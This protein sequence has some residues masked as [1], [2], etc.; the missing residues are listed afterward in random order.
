VGERAA[1]AL[2]ALR[3]KCCEPACRTCAGGLATCSPCTSARTGR[4]PRWLCLA[5]TRRC[6]RS[7]R[8]CRWPDRTERSSPRRHRRSWSC[9]SCRWSC[10][11]CRRRSHPR[12]DRPAGRR[13]LRGLR[14]KSSKSHP[15]T[16]PWPRWHSRPP[17]TSGRLPCSRC[18]APPRFRIRCRRRPPGKCRSSRN[19]RCTTHRS[20]GI[21]RRFPSHRSPQ[22]LRSTSWRRWNR[23]SK[24]HTSCCLRGG[25]PRPP[26]RPS[27]C[28]REERQ[29]PRAW[30]LGPPRRRRIPRSRKTARPPAAR[31]AYEHPF[32]PARPRAAMTQ[33][34]E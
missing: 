4:T 28:R 12:A 15:M 1:R 24:M 7:S 27:R 34:R 21:R 14:R 30:A 8:C 6:R 19:N 29:R 22:A 18:T 20:P 17:G 3:G 32:D 9:S 13:D 5:D 23:L 31:S 16:T 26:P 2:G 11:C 33:T 25:R 10:C